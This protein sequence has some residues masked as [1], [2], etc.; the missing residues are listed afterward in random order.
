MLADPEGAIRAAINH[1]M[2]TKPLRE[3][4][5]PGETVAI[6]VNDTTRVANSH[7]FL[8]ILLDELNG[9]GIPDQD[10]FIVFALGSHRL[11]TGSEME[12]EVG[13]AVAARVRL[14]NSDCKDVD[15]FDYLG[16]TSYGT[17]EFIS[18]W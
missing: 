6:I 3:L 7:V 9:A 4:V 13:T 17:P 10:M 12:S 11:L 2:G 18:V 16:E 5:K 1:P 8:P 14:Y 15:Q